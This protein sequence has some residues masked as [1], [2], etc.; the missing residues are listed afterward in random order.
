MGSARLTMDRPKLGTILGWGLSC[1]RPEDKT[2]LTGANRLYAIIMSASAYPI[3]ASE[4]RM[5]YKL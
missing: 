5:E 2:R 3:L 1:F 4:M